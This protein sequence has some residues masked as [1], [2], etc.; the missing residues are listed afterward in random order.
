MKI[1]GRIKPKW[2]WLFRNIDCTGWISPSIL[3]LVYT[4]SCRQLIDFQLGLDSH[5][6]LT[7]VNDDDEAGIGNGTDI[8]GKENP[9]WPIGSRALKASGSFSA[10][11]PT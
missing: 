10:A 9:R 3:P 1:N 5:W 4:S 8:G 11:R 7:I 6:Q 2:R